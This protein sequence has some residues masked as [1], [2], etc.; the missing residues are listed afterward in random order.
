MFSYG[1]TQK[2]MVDNEKPYEQMDDLGGFPII[3]GNTHMFSIGFY[4][5]WSHK[6]TQHGQKVIG[7]AG[8]RDE[9]QALGYRT[10]GGPEDAGLKYWECWKWVEM[11]DVSHHSLRYFWKLS[12]FWGDGGFCVCLICEFQ[13][14]KMTRLEFFE[15]CWAGKSLQD[16]TAALENLGS[17]SFHFMTKAISKGHTSSIFTSLL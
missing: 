7:Q 15:S 5:W 16:T 11:A 1:C 8:L 12:F 9:V 13:A 3:S 10:R 14:F 17:H 4:V 6:L 2:W